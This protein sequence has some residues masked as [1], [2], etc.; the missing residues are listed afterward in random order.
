MKTSTG[1]LYMSKAK[2]HTYKGKIVIEIK[3]NDVGKFTLEPDDAMNLGVKLL[4]AA[5]ATRTQR[6]E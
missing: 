4:R 6:G 2:V 1:A 5:Y 3:T